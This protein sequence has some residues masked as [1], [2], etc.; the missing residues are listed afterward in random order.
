MSV[1]NSFSTIFNQN[2]FN[3]AISYGD[4]EMIEYLFE[5]GINYE[6]S[7]ITLIIFH[8]NV[9][10]MKI[11]VDHGYII[12][13]DD[14][15]KAVFEG[16]YSMIE[17]ILSLNTV[18]LTQQMGMGISDVDLM[19]FLCKNGLPITEDTVTYAEYTCEYDIVEYL[20]DI[21]NSQK[22]AVK[23]R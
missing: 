7:H 21:M 5:I 12:C 14:L 11:F 15:H 18:T 17:Y 20:Q 1:V 8:K 23:F 6:K 4:I 16:Y 2:L 13:N 10:I 19:D 22:S 3:D 9:D